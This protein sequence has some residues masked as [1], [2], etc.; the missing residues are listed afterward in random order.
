MKNKLATKRMMP[1][2]SEEVYGSKSR[3]DKYT[4]MTESETVFIMH[5]IY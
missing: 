3:A 5:K 2:Y 4:R 1:N